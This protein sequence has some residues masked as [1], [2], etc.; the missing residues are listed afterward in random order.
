M[1]LH[2]IHFVGFFFY[3]RIFG[4][5]RKVP[6][7]S[8]K[9]IEDLPTSVIGPTEAGML[10]WQC[11]FMAHC[12]CNITVLLYENLPMQYTGT[13]NISAVKKVLENVSRKTLI[14]GAR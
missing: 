3:P 8:K 7:A 4:G 9:V 6:P 1:F 14:V 2:N 13:K 5:E 10:P 12:P 11:Y